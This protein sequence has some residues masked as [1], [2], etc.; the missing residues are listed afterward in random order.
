GGPRAQRAGLRHARRTDQAPSTGMIAPLTYD[1]R[2]E[3]RNAATSA[4]S[5][6]WPARPSAAFSSISGKCSAPAAPMISVRMKPGQRAVTRTPRLPYS[7]AADLVT[8]MTPALAAEYTDVALPEL[9]PP[10]DD[11]LTTAPPPVSS[12]A[13]MPYFMPWS[14]PRRSTSMMRS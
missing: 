14:T 4:T 3:H 9:S 1:A 8:A 7:T 6:G 11:Q 12:I 13:R 10:T 5:W 2:S